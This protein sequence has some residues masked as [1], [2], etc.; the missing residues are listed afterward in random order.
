MMR[1]IGR[2]FLTGSTVTVYLIPRLERILAIANREYDVR[3][4]TLRN[5][6]HHFAVL[7]S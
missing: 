3:G 2:P 7:T 5:P 4:L 6:L 1:P